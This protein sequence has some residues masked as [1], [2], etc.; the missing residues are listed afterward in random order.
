MKKKRIVL[1]NV[2]K[3]KYR[4]CHKNSLEKLDN[5]NVS[6]HEKRKMLQKAQVGDGVLQIAS[7]LMLPL[8]AKALKR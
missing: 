3:E 5:A 6:I 2:A 1:S 7:H 4:V 8:L